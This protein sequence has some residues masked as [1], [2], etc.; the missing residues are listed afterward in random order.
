MSKRIPRDIQLAADLARLQT[1]RAVGG[2]EARAEALKE[3]YFPNANSWYDYA[4]IGVNWV[5]AGIS[6]ALVLPPFFAAG[7]FTALW[8]GAACIVGAFFVADLMSAVFHKWLDSYACEQ[9]PFWGSSAK[10][11]RVHHEF[12]NNLNETTYRHNVSAFATFSTFLYALFFLGW[13]AGLPPAAG[14]VLCTMLLLF[15]NGTEIHKQAHRPHP[16][17]FFRWG[18]ATGFFLRRSNHLRHH[19][20]E[21]NSDYGIINGWASGLA[22]RTGIWVKLDLFVWNRFGVL[23]RN[24]IQVPESVPATVLAQWESGERALPREFL[25]YLDAFPRRATDELKL[26]LL[27]VG[28]RAH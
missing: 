5:L 12:P 4:F 27:N 18:Q 17:R 6:L 25:I 15:T 16:G 7:P 26:A 22:E 11:F 8:R 9:N 2:E 3:Y 1:A 20:D 10:A 23:P 19:R 14:L 21:L 24:W 28:K 13:W